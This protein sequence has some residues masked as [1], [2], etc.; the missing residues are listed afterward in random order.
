MVIGESQEKVI[1]YLREHGQGTTKEIGDA[2]YKFSWY[3]RDKGEN[4]Y[5]SSV[6]R[7]WAL[8]VLNRLERRGFVI[9][10]I[11]ENN[12]PVHWK[13]SDSSLTKP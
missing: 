5:G 1:E 12:D 8:T 10:S 11:Q 9:R 4:Y 6:R 7:S 3:G 2:C 13:L